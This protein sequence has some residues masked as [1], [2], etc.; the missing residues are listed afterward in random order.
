M[1]YIARSL[2][3]VALKAARHFLGIVLAGPRRAGRT[4]LIRHLLPRPLLIMSVST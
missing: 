1:R 3:A 2:E 4:S